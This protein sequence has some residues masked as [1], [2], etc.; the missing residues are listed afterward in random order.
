M[1][2]QHSKL[3]ILSAVVSAGALLAFPAATVRATEG[4]NAGIVAG[5]SRERLAR[6]A[7][8]AVCFRGR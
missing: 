6:I 3:Q 7:P 2:M 1:T 8:G 5:M 4:P